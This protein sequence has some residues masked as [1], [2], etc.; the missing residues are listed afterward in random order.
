MIQANVLLPSTGKA[1]DSFVVLDLMRLPLGI[2]TGMGFIGAGAIIRR[3]NLVLGV[4][5]AAT[6]WL[7]TVLGLCF[8]GGQIALGLAGLVLGAIVLT[9]L[10]QLEQHLKRDH[11]GTLTVA[12]AAN[13]P[14]EE[15]IRTALT[16]EGYTIRS[17]GVAY[18][19]AT[20]AE[21]L[22]CQVTW[23]GKAQDARVPA[24]VRTL[25]QRAG[26][27]KVAWSPQTR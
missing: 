9:G 22:S 15:E 27:E 8:G 21:E 20:A 6:L 23:H 19:A 1:P 13:G 17:C 18:T 14:R 7:A 2:L 4:T 24:L 16:N 10:R 11:L 12:V 25:S 26:V 3:D 5:T